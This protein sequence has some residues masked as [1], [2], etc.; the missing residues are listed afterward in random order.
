M[1]FRQYWHHLTNTDDQTYLSRYIPIS[2]AVHDTLSKEPVYL[3]DKNPKRLIKRFIEVLAEKQEAIAA[4]ALR[5]HPYPSDF[6]MLPGEVQKQWRQWVNQVPVIGF[7]SGKYD[8]NMLKEYFVKKISYNKD[9]ECNEDV[10]AAKKENDYMFLTTSKFKFLDVKNYSGP[11]LSYDAWCKSM[12]C[13]LQ[14][15]MFP[16]D[17]LDSHEKLSHEGPVRYEDFYSNLK[18]SNITRDE[19]EQFLKL[20]K[21]NDCTTMGDWLRV[22]NVADVVPF[23]EAFKKMAGQYYLDK[24]DVCKDAV[25]I[26]SI[27]MTYVLNKFLE[28]NKGL[29]LYSPG[30]I[31][32]LCRDIREELQ[33]CSCIGALKCDA[34][35]KE[36]QL[37]MQALE[38]CRCKKAAVYE[39]L[40]TGMVG[41]PAQVFT[42]YHEKDITRKITRG[43]IG[44]D[45]NSLYLYCSGDVMPVA[46]TPWL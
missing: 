16:Y 31:C 38:R 30:G 42:R 28:K 46:K 20:F 1:I 23:I 44:Y 45:A 10:F 9:D 27:S 6:Q 29:E 26:P 35:C 24:V 39:L 37:D 7:N 36:C 13:R 12:V 15:S 5:Q 40:R 25:S 21:E 2:V 11:G 4:D 14:K 43:I 8:L 18:S 33:H 17:C 32:H 3:V 34:Y 22:Y 41:G 19:Y